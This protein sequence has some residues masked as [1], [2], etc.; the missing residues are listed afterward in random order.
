MLRLSKSSI[1]YMNIVRHKETKDIMGVFESWNGKAER[2]VEILGNDYEVVEYNLN[3]SKELLLDKQQQYLEE[4][5]TWAREIDNIL[6]PKNEIGASITLPTNKLGKLAQKDI[7]SRGKYTWEYYDIKHIEFY[8]NENTLDI[9]RVFED[10]KKSLV[11]YFD[12]C[13]LHLKNQYEKTTIRAI[14]KKL[15]KE[16]DK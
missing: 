4:E 16:S 1:T 15:V 7:T 8:R 5:L 9:Y 10:D 6:A 2:L 12:E 3:Y 14:V 13:G 11:G